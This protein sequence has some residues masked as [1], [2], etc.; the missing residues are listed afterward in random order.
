MTPDF[1]GAFLIG[2][3]GAGHCMGM[4]GGIASILSIGSNDERPSLVV[5]FFYNIGRLTS[6]A[7]IG[8]LIGGSL[9][10]LVQFG[11]L[12]H[13]LAWLRLIA[14]FF[15]ILVALY[16]AKWWHGLIAVENI[17]KFFWKYLS[18]VGRH[19]LPLRHTYHAVP[20]GFI[21][22]WLPCGLVYSAL[23]WSAVSGSAFNGSLIMLAFGTGTLPAML[24]V[25]YGATYFHKF[26]RSNI[27]RNISAITLIIY[28]LYT[29]EGAIRM[30]DI[31]PK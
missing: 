16:I 29:A 3:A 30:L 9:S 17:G 4:C 14:S 1:I 20:F 13:P 19:F 12:T 28:A 2:L 10:S 31:M 23:T 27:F 11:G 26:Q 8:A 24:T 25:G 22:G 5:P 7:F 18:P 21:W 6:Y 15:M